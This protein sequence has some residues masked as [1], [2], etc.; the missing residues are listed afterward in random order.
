MGAEEFVPSEVTTEFDRVW[1]NIGPEKKS[2]RQFLGNMDARPF[3]DVTCVGN[4]V[5]I[6]VNMGMN[7]Q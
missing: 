3:A 5:S 1:A 4:F 6:M 7:V 2:I